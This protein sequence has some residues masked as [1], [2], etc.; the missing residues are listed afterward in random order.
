MA[1]GTAFH[2]HNITMTIVSIAL[3]FVFGYLLTTLSLVKKGSQIKQAVKAAVATDT[4]SIISMELID[5]VFVWLIP[6]ALDATLNQPLFWLSLLA[7]LVVAFSLTVP[8][9]RWFIAEKGHSHH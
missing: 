8:V 5:N 7:S 4:V 2:W 1:I 6:G 9:N 3:S